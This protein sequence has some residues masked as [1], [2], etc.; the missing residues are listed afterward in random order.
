[1]MRNLGIKDDYNVER[2]VLSSDEDRTLFR[3]RCRDRDYLTFQPGRKLSSL[4]PETAITD[5]CE[6][7][8]D[9]SRIRVRKMVEKDKDFCGDEHCTLEPTLPITVDEARKKST[10]ENTIMK[11]GKNKLI[12]ECVK[13]AGLED[14]IE[15][16][17]A[18][19]AALEATKGGSDCFDSDED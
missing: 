12:S 10:S 11:W 19:I 5:E 18:Q 14:E 17:R 4:D 9:V 7:F 15:T 3:M 13:N 16:L 8:F 2:K 6:G 1:M